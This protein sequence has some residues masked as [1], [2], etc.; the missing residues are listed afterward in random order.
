[1]QVKEL[2]SEYDRH[3]KQTIGVT[4]STRCQYIHYVQRF[5][6]EAF[7]DA[8][9]DKLSHLQPGELIQYVIK[10]REHHNEPVLKS[11]V[12]AL[13]SF[14][15]FLQMKGLCEARLVNAVPSI[16]AW[17]LS[18]IPNFLTNEQLN[19]FLASFDRKSPTGRR[20]YAIALCL[21]RLGLRRKEVTHLALDDI[22]WRSGIL[23]ITTSK[24]RRFSTLPLPEDVGKAIVDY[25]RNGR[26]PTEERRVFVCHRHRVGAPLQS[27]AIGTLIRRRFKRTR[28]KVPGGTHI[29]RHTVAT[30]MVQQGVSI[31][32][33]AD[34]LRHRSLDTTVIYT[35]V[36]LPMLL[37]VALPWPKEGETT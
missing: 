27:A 32:E 10:Q 11:M 30:H 7:T 33:V 24:S 13:R 17:K 36:N 35:K 3:L 19:K 29:L 12:T 18:R 6:R 2:I 5:L 21:A 31:K 28:M 4:E 16:P 15:R 14:L 25:L 9:Q 26:P 1:M 20:D 37:E 22:D 8:F 23:R 34:F